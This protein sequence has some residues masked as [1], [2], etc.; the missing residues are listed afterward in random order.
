MNEETTQEVGCDKY[1]LHPGLIQKVLNMENGHV[2][3]TS[4]SS[5]SILNSTD[6]AGNKLM[7]DIRNTHIQ[8]SLRDNRK[9]TA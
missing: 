2:L 4:R 1:Y 8:E 7:S 3:I 9:K 5:R 6:I